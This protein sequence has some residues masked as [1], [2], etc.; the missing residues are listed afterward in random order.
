MRECKGE[1]LIT[2]NAYLKT[3]NHTQYFALTWFFSEE[4]EKIK[5]TV[6]HF[7]YKPITEVAQML[8]DTENQSFIRYQRPHRLLCANF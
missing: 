6:K 8:E 1:Q 2:Q 3:P 4:E 5:T 7:M